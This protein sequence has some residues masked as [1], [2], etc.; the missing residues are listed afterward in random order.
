L[1]ILVTLACEMT[2]TPGP[3]AGPSTVATV[4]PPPP[5][6]EAGLQA[7]LEALQV[8]DYAGAIAAERQRRDAEATLAVIAARQTLTAEAREAEV[9]TLAWQQTLTTEAVR[10]EQTVT[11]WQLTVE[12]QQARETATAEANRTATA[13]AE[14]REQRTLTGRGQPDGRRGADDGDGLV[15][16]VDCR[17]RRGCSPIHSIERMADYAQQ[18]THLLNA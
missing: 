17:G 12:A 13:V 6:T 10:A 5:V 2:V 11:A 1:L 3:V 15:P 8:E 9:A 16:H 4:S 7:T 14:V 18:L